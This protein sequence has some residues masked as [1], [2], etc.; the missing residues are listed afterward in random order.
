MHLLGGLNEYV[1][2]LKIDKNE[3]AR[4][5]V[6]PRVDLQRTWGETSYRMAALSEI[7]RT[8]LERRV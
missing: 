7:T 8:A 5:S 6:R 2:K 4:C 3:Q 1:K